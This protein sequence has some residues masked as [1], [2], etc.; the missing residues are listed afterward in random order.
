MDYCEAIN[1]LPGSKENGLYGKSCL[2]TWDMTDEEIISVARGACALKA[3]RDNNISP[4]IF[5]S[6]IAVSMFT[7]KDSGMELAY[8]S[9]CDLLGLT[10]IE[11]DRN[12]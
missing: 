8:A 10:I 2:K 3:L 11:K 12:M 4:K 6:G 1:K 7:K 9:G 5:D